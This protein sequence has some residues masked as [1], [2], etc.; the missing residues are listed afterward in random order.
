MGRKRLKITWGIDTEDLL[1]KYREANDARIATRILMILH[2]KNGK[3]ARETADI[4]FVDPV[5]VGRWVKRF[6]ELGP[7]GLGDEDRPGRPTK[8]DHENLISA[9]NQ[10]PADFGYDKQVWD[11]GLVVSYLLEHQNVE[12]HPNY[13]YKLIRSLGFSLVKPSSRDY[14]SDPEKVQIFKKK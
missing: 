12:I 14:K 5:T 4:L 7:D 11:V 6:N 13:V 3:S 9:L 8:V 10:S 1:E 2:V